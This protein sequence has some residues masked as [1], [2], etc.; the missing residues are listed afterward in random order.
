[1]KISWAFALAPHNGDLPGMLLVEEGLSLCDGVTMLVEDMAFERP[2]A[3]EHED[4]EP[5]FWFTK[6][7]KND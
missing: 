5:E 2:R 6:E 3:D 7:N 4:Q 1:M